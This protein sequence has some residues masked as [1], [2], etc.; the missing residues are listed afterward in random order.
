M[1]YKNFV[2]SEKAIQAG[3]SHPCRELSGEFHFTV[4]S[5]PDWQEDIGIYFNNIE[6][7]INSIYI[8][9]FLFQNLDVFFEDE[10]IVHREHFENKEVRP[11]YYVCYNADPKEHRVRLVE[12]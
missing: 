12:N 11:H 4:L 9:T 2:K 1:I 6:A 8:D 5:F 3:V 7:D 10:K